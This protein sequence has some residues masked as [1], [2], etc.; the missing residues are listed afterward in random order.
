[1]DVVFNLMFQVEEG[2]RPDTGLWYICT[3][4]QMQEN[5]YCTN[6]ENMKYGECINSTNNSLACRMQTKE[7][8]NRK[9]NM[10]FK[11]GKSFK[12]LEMKIFSRQ[13]SWLSL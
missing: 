12:L 6:T 9:E 8:R 4:N 13:E 1:M 10:R 7:A 2:H 11:R 3:V 5:N